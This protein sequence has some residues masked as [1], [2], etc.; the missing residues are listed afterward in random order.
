MAEGKRG[1]LVVKYTND[2]K[3][4]HLPG[5]VGPSKIGGHGFPTLGR[6]QIPGGRP[7]NF[8]T[9]AQPASITFLGAGAGALPRDA[10]RA[11]RL[12]RTLRSLSRL[13][14]K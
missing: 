8:S 4:A 2:R 7:K 14:P 1:P 10:G 12:G 3:F 5:G 6:V 13:F 11:A 9:N